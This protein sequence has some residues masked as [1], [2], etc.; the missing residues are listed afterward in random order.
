MQRHISTLSTLYIYNMYLYKKYL[1]QAPDPADVRAP[2]RHGGT[3]SAQPRQGMRCLAQHS[4][5]IASPKHLHHLSLLYLVIETI[6]HLYVAKPAPR[7]C[8]W[9]SMTWTAAPSA[10]GCTWPPA[11][12]WSRGAE[13]LHISRYI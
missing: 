4:Y 9:W 2:P 8:V 13:Y 3:H 1:L 10:P 6:L 12:R 7:T 5:S 11:P